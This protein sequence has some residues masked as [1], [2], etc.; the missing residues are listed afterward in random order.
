MSWVPNQNRE[1]VTHINQAKIWVIIRQPST[2]LISAI[3]TTKHKKNYLIFKHLYITP[4]L[5]KEENSGRIYGR[6]PLIF[7][8]S[9]WNLRKTVGTQRVKKGESKNYCV[10]CHHTWDL[11]T[12]RS[13]FSVLFQIRQLPNKVIKGKLKSYDHWLRF[14]LTIFLYHQRQSFY[15]G[16][17]V[18]YLVK[19]SGC[20]L[21]LSTLSV[22]IFPLLIFYSKLIRTYFSCL[23][24]C[25]S[26]YS[27]NFA[28][29]NYL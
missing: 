16:M 20:R 28:S 23:C 17:T 25:E 2:V 21:M 7:G 14:P 22:L 18:A 12:Q 26:L 8:I 3:W 6:K 9:N 10:W 29:I 15:S 4:W 13:K 24:F 5:H 1:Y 27:N 19:Q 11:Q